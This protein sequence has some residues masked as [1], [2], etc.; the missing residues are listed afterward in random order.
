MTSHGT[1]DEAID[2]LLAQM[3]PPDPGLIEPG[4]KHNIYSLRKR[5]MAVT[6]NTVHPSLAILHGP[7]PSAG[8]LETFCWEAFT[9]HRLAFAYEQ[10]FV[11][12]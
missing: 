7:A 11:N 10:L 9:Y 4:E 2:A 6:I 12:R 1:L 5:P 3:N 8:L